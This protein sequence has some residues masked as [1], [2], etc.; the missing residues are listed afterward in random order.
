MQVAGGQYDP[1]PLNNQA[2]ATIS[3][4]PSVNLAVVL[5]ASKQTVVMG[6][7][8]T[9]T[10]SVKNTGPNP[11][12]SVVLTLPI[13]SNLVFDSTNA[14]DGT[15]SLDGGQFVAQL[16][17]LDPGSSVQI[18]LV[19]TPQTVGTITQTASVTAE[20]NQLDP[21]NETATTTVTVLESPALSSSVRLLF[22]PS[23]RLEWPSFRSFARSA[24]SER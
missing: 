5:G 19:V 22:P 1:N 23:T 13:G 16:G 2:E 11:A 8:V 4:S 21:A 9:M 20:E 7:P 17:E 12:T 18:S 10:A 3:V 24:R 14:S 15:S 6:E